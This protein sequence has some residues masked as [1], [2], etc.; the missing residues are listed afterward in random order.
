MDGKLAVIMSI[1][2]SDD[3]EA[4]KVSLDSLINQTYPCDIFLYQD[5]E[6]PSQLNDVLQSYLHFNQV[7]LTTGSVRLC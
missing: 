3:P 1:Y 4:F 2:K 5:G 6:I 7:K